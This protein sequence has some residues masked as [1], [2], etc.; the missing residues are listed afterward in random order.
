MSEIG[1]VAN[2]PVLKKVLAKV[3]LLVPS[4][5]PTK[6]Y[7]QLPLQAMRCN[8]LREVEMEEKACH[9]A[10]YETP[11]PVNTVSDQDTP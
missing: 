11:R 8:S 1:L 5:A 2:S 6:A 3:M 10:L 7:P 4:L 9:K